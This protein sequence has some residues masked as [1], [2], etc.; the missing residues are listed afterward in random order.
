MW[1]V[2]RRSPGGQGDRERLREEIRQLRWEKEI[3]IDY[4]TKVFTYMN[5]VYISI[6]Q[7]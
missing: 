2:S 4:Q 7:Q 1:E 5:T 3:V 6:Y